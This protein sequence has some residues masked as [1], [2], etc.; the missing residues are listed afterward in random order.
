MSGTIFDWFDLSPR[1]PHRPQTQSVLSGKI[2]RLVFAH[3]AKKAGILPIAYHHQKSESLR[4]HTHDFFEL[5]FVLEGNGEHCLEDRSDPIRP[6]DFIFVNNQ[7]PHMIRAK[8]ENFRIANLCFL[9]SALGY[10]DRALGNHN[11]LN[12]YTLLTPFGEAEADGGTLLFRPAESLRKKITFLFLWMSELFFEDAEKNKSILHNLLESLVQVILEAYRKER[13]AKNRENV[14][15]F[16]ALHWI[17]AHYL[18]KISLDHIAR[19]YAISKSYFST[20]FNRTL[21]KNLN[22]YV[23][24]LRIQEAKR[25]LR[26][27]RL[28]V[29]S[30]AAETGFETLPHFSGVFRKLA[31]I[32]PKAFRESGISGKTI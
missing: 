18:E 32:S 7:K 22:E 8:T 20:L 4:F 21:G 5:F 16:D 1:S 30:I 24:T 29:S 13:P 25:L 6:G 26:K 14:L 31:G 12:F 3:Q 23:N 28:P 2:Q 17:H 9:P 10:D 15:L 19:H 11:L 27:T